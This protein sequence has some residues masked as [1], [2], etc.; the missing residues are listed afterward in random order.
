M[1][2]VPFGRLAMAIL[3]LGTI[4]SRAEA[5]LEVDPDQQYLLLATTRTGTM[6]S[7]LNEAGT[8]G[9]RVVSGAPTSG[10]E[11]VIFLQRAVE[12]RDTYEYRLLATSRTSTMQEELDAAA[13]EGFRLLA[14]TPIC[15]KRGF[16]GDELVVAL[17]RS[18]EGDQRYAYRLLATTQTSAMQEEVTQAVAEGFAISGLFSCDEH[19][20]I[21]EREAAS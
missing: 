7:E 8:L 4:V 19:I 12:P 11:L 10:E 2:F 3:L 5:Q 15:K 9:F 18:P 21:M 17:E 13:A 6:E 20:V 1:S 16:G 14:R